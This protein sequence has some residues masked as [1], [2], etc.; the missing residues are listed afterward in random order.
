MRRATA[1]VSTVLLILVSIAVAEAALLAMLVIFAYI[2]RLNFGV[3]LG[4]QYL[5]MWFPPAAEPSVAVRTAGAIVSILFTLGCGAGA[6][7]WRYRR[8]RPA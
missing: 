3:Q 8:W 7:V 1:A 6:G 5:Q 4:E 2:L